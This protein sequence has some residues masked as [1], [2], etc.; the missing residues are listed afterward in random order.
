[1]KRILLVLFATLDTLPPIGIRAPMGPALASLP[2]LV[3]LSFA[4]VTA[5]QGPQVTQTYAFENVTVIPMDSER[6]LTGQTVVVREGRI[7]EI[8]ASS[9]VQIPADALRIDG[10]GRYLTPALAEM[11]ARLPS[12][13]DPLRVLVLD[14]T[15]FLYLAN[16]IT[17][18]RVME[19][20]PYQLDLRQAIARGEI[21]GPALYVGSPSL[22]RESGTDSD[23]VRAMVDTYAEAGY[24]FL[25]V[26][27]GLSPGGWND[28]MEVA[29]GLGISY[30]GRVPAEVGVLQAIEDGMS[31]MSCLDGYLEVTR[32]DNLSGGASEVQVLEATDSGKLEEVA[33][34]TAEA[35]V[36]LVPCQY[37]SHHQAGWN[38]LF[39]G[40]SE[41]ESVLELP[42]FRYVTQARRDE[43]ATAAR[44]LWDGVTP[45]AAAAHA[46]WRRELLTALL[47]SGSIVLMG[48]D[49][50]GLFN[51]P[52][53]AV[54]RELPLMVDA[55]MSPYEV[56]KSGTR[57]VARFVEEHL[58]QAADFG[59]IAE[60]N[61]ADLL[62]LEENPLESVAALQARVGV[63]ARG[64]WL[65]EEEIQERLGGIAAR[66]GDAGTYGP[67]YDPQAQ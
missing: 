32:E 8:A 30:A 27:S 19:G 52:G 20:S 55:G 46:M 57:N 53:S 51:V 26:D 49:S 24:D 63:M 7:A 64:T 65:T 21:L 60:G 58:G 23:A 59:T 45:Q 5:Q 22:V 34:V 61:W 2:T 10:Q 15:L 9:S 54:H 67:G 43:F 42:E 50:P 56:L 1:M 33:R 36:Y 25:S 14:E 18:V 48:T 11:H 4:A 66:Y 38:Q 6:A 13:D 62:L 47:E 39:G 41:V 40:L 37:L 17:T 16:G 12:E 35:G 44:D 31:G 3:A 29:Q 28:L